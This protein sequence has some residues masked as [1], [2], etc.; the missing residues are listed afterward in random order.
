[1]LLKTNNFVDVPKETTIVTLAYMYILH[2]Y[3]KYN[4]LFYIRYNFEYLSIRFF[5][6]KKRVKQN[7]LGFK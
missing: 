4:F 2:A 6:H 1:M 5:N 7:A 3:N